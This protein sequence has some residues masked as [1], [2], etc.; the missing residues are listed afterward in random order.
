[1]LPEAVPMVLLGSG[2]RKVDLG[3]TILYLFGAIALFI[4]VW[5]TW[6]AYTRRAAVSEAAANKAGGGATPR[7]K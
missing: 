6:G 5:I 1:L 7:E 4:A 3:Q 2:L